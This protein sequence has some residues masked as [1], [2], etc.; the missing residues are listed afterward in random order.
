MN[1]QWLIV[2]AGFIG[3]YINIS[4]AGHDPTKIIWDWIAFGSAL[5]A[6]G[7]AQPA[8]GDAPALVQIATG[9]GAFVYGYGQVMAG[10]GF[11]YSIGFNLL[12]I[13]QGLV[14]AG[15]IHANNPNVTQS[16]IVQKVIGT[17]G[18]AK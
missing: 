7:Y 4:V 5:S 16:T 12:G 13:A 2:I 8:M 6:A 10:S 15:L 3:T 11:R 18:A 14:F 1:R 9:V 17:N